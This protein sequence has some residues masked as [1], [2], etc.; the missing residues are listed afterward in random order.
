MPSGADYLCLRRDGGAN[1]H[2][3]R[4]VPCGCEGIRLFDTR[5]HIEPHQFCGAD[6]DEDAG[7][8]VGFFPLMASRN[9]LNIAFSPDVMDQSRRLPTSSAA[10]FS[11]SLSRSQRF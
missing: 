7:G 6:H 3:N 2:S 1:R 9:S 5:D 4:A 11:M 8:D 10:T